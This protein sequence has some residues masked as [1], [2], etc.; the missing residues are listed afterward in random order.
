LRNPK[1]EEKSAPPEKK[2]AGPVEKSPHTHLRIFVNPKAFFGL[3]VGSGSTVGVGGSTYNA[4]LQLA[5]ALVG[6]IY[7]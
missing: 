1:S 3:S 6:T 2:S 5:K 4:I 7:I